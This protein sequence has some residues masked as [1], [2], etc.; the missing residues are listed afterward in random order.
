[1]LKIKYFSI[2]INVLSVLCDNVIDVDD[3]LS[4]DYMP[5]RLLL[6]ENPGNEGNYKNE[7]T[8]YDNETFDNMTGTFNDAYFTMGYHR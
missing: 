1:M 4:I 8:S 7:T 3:I 6:L 2:L 5:G